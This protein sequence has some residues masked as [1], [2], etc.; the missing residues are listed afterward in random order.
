MCMEEEK[1][2]VEQALESTAAFKEMY[3]T[4][5]F[6][7]NG[8][9]EETVSQMSPQ[10]KSALSAKAADAMAQE[11]SASF[12]LISIKELLMLMAFVILAIILSRQ[13]MT[14]Q[15]LL[16]QMPVL[17]N[18]VSQMVGWVSFSF[19]LLWTVDAAYSRLGGRGQRLLSFF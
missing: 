12:Q 6:I 8:L 10:F 18:K 2:V 14:E 5:L 13:T 3:Q 1:K 4:I 17:D 19:V 7:D 16:F 15:S 9:K 11:K